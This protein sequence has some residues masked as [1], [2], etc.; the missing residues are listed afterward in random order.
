VAYRYSQSR[1]EPGEP[2][3]TIRVRSL[4]IPPGVPDFLSRT[5]V[6]PRG[7]VTLQG[8]AW[9]GGS[10]ITGVEVSVDGGATWSPAELERPASRY[11]WQAWSYVWG[12][13]TPGTHELC[14][15]ARDAAGNVQP[16]DQ[17]WTARG[18]GNNMVHRVPVVVT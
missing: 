17:H 15:R 11:A 3:T 18:M 7:A 8:R 10:A 6:V 4:M 1:K 2:V 14:C 5:R 16:V 9:S 13:S 12:A